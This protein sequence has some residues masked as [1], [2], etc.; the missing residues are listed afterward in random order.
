M[1]TLG[2][3]KLETLQTHIQ[4]NKSVQRKDGIPSPSLPETHIYTFQWN[5]ID[6]TVHLI[7]TL[8][9]YSPI[10]ILFQFFQSMIEKNFPIEPYFEKW[11]KYAH[12][13]DGDDPEWVR[14]KMNE[15]LVYHEQARLEKKLP[16]SIKAPLNKKI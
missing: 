16:K 10:D 5:P 9:A 15:I 13:I 6:W 3:D 1:S 8:D 7:S 12:H 4:K 11:V 2:F 14:S